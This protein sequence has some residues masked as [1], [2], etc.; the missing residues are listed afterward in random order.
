MIK[1]AN[2]RSHI[3][4][5]VAGLLLLIGGCARMP[6]IEKTP[7]TPKS[8]G[9]L[10]SYLIANKPD[11]DVFRLIGPFTVETLGNLEIAVS[12]GERIETDLFLA[13]HAEK[14]PLVVFVHGHDNSKDSH[15]Y[16]AMHVAS[17]GMHALTVQ[18]PNN[19]PWVANGKT[20]AT[21]VNT[22][23][24]R[25]EF[26]GGR[27]D[28]NRIVLVGHSFGG[29]A[30][31]IALAETSHAT[32]GIL[33]DPAGVGRDLPG[34]LGRVRSPVL[35]LGA[36]ERVFAARNRDYFYR[37]IRSGVSEVS[38]TNAT[39]EDA[40]FPAE[41]GPTTEAL[42]ITFASAI[43][44]ASFSLALHRQFDYAWASF[45]SDLNTGKLFGMKRK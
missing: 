14:A 39:H 13:G 7:L 24:T 8:L 12:T 37:Y 5:V 40:Q 18:L 22:L 28:V 38:V 42:Q 20:L 34:Y 9:E 21:L 23:Y 19:G 35:V 45:R 41:S 3:F 30:V 32:G 4:C 2:Y 25:P 16:Q 36:D 33:L 44:A 6:N 1:M 43:T 29:A 31:A 26:A 11:L 27:V 10:Q 15:A 17:W